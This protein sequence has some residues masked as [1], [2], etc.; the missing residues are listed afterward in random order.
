MGSGGQ[1]SGCGAR[2]G[3]W[4]ARA[5]KPEVG[6][7]PKSPTLWGRRACRGRACRAGQAAGGA[8]ARVSAPVGGPLRAV[9]PAAGR[10]RCLGGA[11]VAASTGTSAR[12]ECGA[13]RAGRLVASGLTESPTRRSRRACRGRTPRAGRA[14]AG[15]RAGHR[16][17]D[18]GVGG[19]QY[20]LPGGGG[21]RG[22][23]VCPQ[24]ATWG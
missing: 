18:R 13:V 17:E 7:G 23:G 11:W 12:R 16:T 6:R 24:P 9:G 20:A 19:K 5:A 14:A 15:A 1:P 3:R 22:A 8:R 4:E 2:G 10:K 21:V